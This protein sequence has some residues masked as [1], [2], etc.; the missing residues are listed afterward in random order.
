MSKNSIKSNIEAL[1]GWLK[2]LERGKKVGDDKKV[3]QKGKK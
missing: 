3:K 1:T 2:Q